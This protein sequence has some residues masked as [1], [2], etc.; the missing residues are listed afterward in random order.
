M[1]QLKMQGHKLQIV[2][3]DYNQMKLVIKLL[4]DKNSMNCC[5]YFN[6]ILR[7]FNSCSFTHCF[8]IQQD[9]EVR[10]GGISFNDNGNQMTIIFIRSSWTRKKYSFTWKCSVRLLPRGW[11]FVPD[12]KFDNLRIP[13]LNENRGQLMQLRDERIDRRL[14][15]RK[16]ERKMKELA[17]D[18]QVEYVEIILL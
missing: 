3:P 2:E 14:K 15:D 8:C 12:I 16:E 4:V 1:E 11:Y 13:S 18:T 5:R 7:K 9:D 6:I 10:F 17:T